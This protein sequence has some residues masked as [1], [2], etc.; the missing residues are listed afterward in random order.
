MG[1]VYR[2]RSTNYLNQIKAYKKI[3]DTWETINKTKQN[4]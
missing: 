1:A 4:K 3:T 2:K